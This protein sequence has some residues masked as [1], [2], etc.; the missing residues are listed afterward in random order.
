MVMIQD[1][2]AGKVLA[3]DRVKNWR[4]YSFPGGKIEK[5]ESFIDSA[6]REAKEETGLDV[7]NLKSCGVIHWVNTIN[8]SRYLSFLYKTSD[9]SGELLEKTSEGTNVWM[10]VD[11]LFAAKSENLLH[12]ILHMFLRDEYSEAFGSWSCEDDWSIDKFI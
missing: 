2:A 10:S 11:E 1:A 9:F 12:E 4:G 8:D 7:C 6:I 3:L 5:G